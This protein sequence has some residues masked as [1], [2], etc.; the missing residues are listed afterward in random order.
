MQFRRFVIDGI[1]QTRVHIVEKENVGHVLA[2]HR[3]R[4]VERE[5][6]LQNFI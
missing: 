2:P 4:L 1:L 3:S 6:R 5:S